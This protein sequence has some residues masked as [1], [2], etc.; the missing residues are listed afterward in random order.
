MAYQEIAHGQTHWDSPLNAMLKELYDTSKTLSDK[1]SLAYERIEE[2]NGL[3]LTNGWQKNEC[4]IDVLPFLNGKTL[5]IC[6]LSISHPNLAPVNGA[7]LLI[8]PSKAS[9]FV[10]QFIGGSVSGELSFYGIDVSHI[11]YHYAPADGHNHDVQVDI[12]FM[13]F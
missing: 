1:T 6:H 3:V 8:V 4:Y 12:T 9:I 10:A 11:G 7:P 2:K 5:K 13:Y